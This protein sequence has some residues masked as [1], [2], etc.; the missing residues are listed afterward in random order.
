MT[1]DWLHESDLGPHMKVTLQLQSIAKRIKN[2]NKHQDFVIRI[3]SDCS[4]NMK[5][6]YFIIIISTF[7]NLKHFYAK[8]EKWLLA[9][10]STE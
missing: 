9:V 10:C 3:N 2:N 5:S 6:N 4:N 8:N 7:S 1:S